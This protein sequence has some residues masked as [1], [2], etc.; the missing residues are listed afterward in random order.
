MARHAIIEYSLK[1]YGLR[2]RWK[3]DITDWDPPRFF[4]DSQL[5]GPYELWEHR[6]YFEEEDG[7]TRMT[8]I[9]DY[10]PPGGPFSNLVNSLMVKKKLEKI[11]DYRAE[12]ISREFPG[13]D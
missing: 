5:R 9:V 13:S 1:L 12:R 4:R 11:F 10:A 3:T 8:D 7:G 2:F 6:H